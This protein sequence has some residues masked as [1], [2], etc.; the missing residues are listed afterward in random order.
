MHWG[1]RQSIHDMMV[2][3]YINIFK[4]MPVYGHGNEDT[5][6]ISLGFYSGKSTKV[7]DLDN[8]SMILKWAIDAWKTTQTFDDNFNFVTEVR[9]KYRGKKAKEEMWFQVEKNVE[10]DL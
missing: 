8:A 4:S 9:I 5:Y 1:K 6:R 10:D 7:Y 3:E 2:T